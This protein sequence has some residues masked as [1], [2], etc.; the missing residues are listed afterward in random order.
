M[1][2]EI[3]IPANQNR[4]FA[5]MTTNPHRVLADEVLAIALLELE[6]EGV[7]NQILSEALFDYTVIEM[8]PDDPITTATAMT[9]ISQLH[10]FRDR[11]QDKIDRIEEIYSD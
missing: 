4:S 9:W 2:K 3:D 10:R 11:L 7:H 8:E 1:S 5:E 6:K